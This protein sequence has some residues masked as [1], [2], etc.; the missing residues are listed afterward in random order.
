[1]L[2][3]HHNKHGE[4]ELIGNSYLNKMVSI[5]IPVIQINDYV[6]EAIP[7]FL[8]LDYPHFEII[9]LPDSEGKEVFPK[10]RIIPTG[11]IGPAAKRDLALMHANGEILAFIDDD[12]YPG[13]NWLKNAVQYFTDDSIGVVCGPAVTP[14]EDNI[15]QQASGK[16]YESTLCCG[17]YTYR[18]RTEKSREV[19]SFAPTVNFIVRKDVFVAAGGF[20]CPYYPGEDVKLCAKIRGKLGKKIIYDPKILVWH[21]RRELFREHLEQVKQYGLHRGFFARNYPEIS[22]SPAH[23]LPGFFVAGLFTGAILS[24][25]FPSIWYISLGILSIYFL[26]LLAAVIGIKDIKLAFLT[27]TGIAMTHFVFGINFMR[28]FFSKSLSK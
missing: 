6:R 5:L 24:V 9:I 7:H 22:T 11:K 4:N 21:H 17:P 16:V 13:Q 25:F 3:M 19:N 27:A 23:Y 20:D 1:M 2:I 14:P 8:N 28:G 15:F 12:A 26:A 10:V 18:Y